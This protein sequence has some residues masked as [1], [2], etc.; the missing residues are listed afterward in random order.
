MPTSRILCLC[1]LGC[2]LILQGCAARAPVQTNDLCTLFDRQSGW[3][4][5]AEQAAER[6][7]GPLP[8]AMAIMRQES[9]FKANA[10]P[11]RRYFLGI[12]PWARASSAYGYAQ[13][14]DSTWKTYLSE[15][16][17][18]FRRRSNFGDSIDFI[19][20]YMHKTWKIN[21]IPKTDARRQYLNYHEGQAGYRRGTHRNKPWLQST[22][23]RVAQ[24]AQRYT[25]QYRNCR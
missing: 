18:W 15:T 20:W 10:R 5:S 3:R 17:G 12:I 24:Q 6:W 11:R 19:Q 13:A 8:V 22:A 4:R 21:R 23:K 14:I 7:G 25:A 2:T 16:S 1:L 9:S